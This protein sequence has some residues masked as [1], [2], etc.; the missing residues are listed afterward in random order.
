MVSHL[1]RIF[2]EI[3]D[4]LNLKYLSY[5]LRKENAAM[6]TYVA[7]QGPIVTRHIRFSIVVPTFG[8]PLRYVKEFVES[9]RRQTYPNWELCVCDDGDPNLD[10]SLYFE[11]LQRQMPEK[12]KFVRSPKN[13][14]IC[15]AT[16]RGMS[17]AGGDYFVLADVDDVLHRRA[18]EL[19]AVTATAKPK[20][21]FLYS[22]HDY[23]TEWSYRLHPMLKPGWSPELL[24]HVNY[25]NHLKALRRDLALEICAVSF[26]SQYNGSQDWNLC[27][28]VL[29]HGH[30]IAHIPFVLYHWR[31]RKGSMADNVHSKPWAVEA[32]ARLRK[33][34]V[35]QNFKGL[36]FDPVANQFSLEQRSKI[37]SLKISNL[38]SDETI[39]DT[40]QRIKH[41]VSKVQADIVFFEGQQTVPFDQKAKLAANCQ[42]PKVGCVWPFRAAG[43]RTAYTLMPL[44]HGD[45]VAVPVVVARSS[46]SNYSGNVLAG[47]LD[48]MSIK[49]ELLL[50]LLEEILSEPLPVK[51]EGSSLD[52]V[53]VLISIA[54]LS[55]G[56]RN[57]SSNA[58]TIPNESGPVRL[59][60]EF[61]PAFDPYI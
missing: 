28:Q 23:M 58:A 22:N 41:Q 14:G 46:F 56:M 20:A 1:K 11:N 40:L 25:I 52:A 49:R 55:R 38:Q 34:F 16:T 60:A 15:G 53:G 30:S 35:A 5:R 59:P 31:A 7:D 44:S 2:S 27:L 37:E 18:L 48:G 17:L 33:N 24:Y 54:S 19:F 13:E 3:D 47:P 32:Q 6:D 26:D 39:A 42:L 9:I 43:L 4:R 10:V 12:I 21:D 45:T 8:I 29:Q 51:F 61:L 57:M 50:S 36:T